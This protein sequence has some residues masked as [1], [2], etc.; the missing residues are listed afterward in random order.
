MD[1]A[2]EAVAAPVPAAAGE[3]EQLT[4]EL[5][6]AKANVDVAVAD[7]A[8]G[9]VAELTKRLNNLQEKVDRLTGEYCVSHRSLIALDVVVCKQAK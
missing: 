5:N 8:W 7:K 9:A 6:A 4:A 2:A 3:L 1:T